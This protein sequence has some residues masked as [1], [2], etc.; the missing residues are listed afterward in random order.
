MPSTAARLAR[1]KIVIYYAAMAWFLVLFI[2]YF[3]LHEL[4]G[5]YLANLVSGVTPAHLSVQWVRFFGLPLFP[6]S[7]TLHAGAPSLWSRLAGGIVAGVVLLGVSYAWRGA[8]RRH[9]YTV[10]W[11]LFI[12]TLGFALSGLLEGFMEGFFNE[13]HRRSGELLAL[14]VLTFL[15]PPVAGAWHFRATILGMVRKQERQ[16]ESG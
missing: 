4:A 6:A 2:G 9:D 15:M 14:V 10:L 11:W 16:D 7:V 3:Y 8:W 13:Y 1:D 5:H 12:V